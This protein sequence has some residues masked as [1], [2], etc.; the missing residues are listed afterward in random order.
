MVEAE[1]VECSPRV[2]EQMKKEISE[3]VNRYFELD[4]DAYEI[5]VVLKQNKKRA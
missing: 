3:I 5:K 1:P 2:L 4:T